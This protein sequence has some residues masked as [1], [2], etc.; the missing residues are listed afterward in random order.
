M[1]LKRRPPNKMKGQGRA[2][3]PLVAVKASA[4]RRGPEGEVL[5]GPDEQLEVEGPS[6]AG[7]G[8]F[9]SG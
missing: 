7:N 1:G 4:K 5:P 9:A 3:P 2:V 8:S 6:P